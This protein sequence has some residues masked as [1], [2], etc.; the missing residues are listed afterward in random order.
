MSHIITLFLF[1]M[2]LY[3]KVNST[4][5]IV[6]WTITA[7]ML[8]GHISMAAKGKLVHQRLDALEKKLGQKEA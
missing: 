3:E 4:A 2:F 6:T 7:L 8:F 1:G 5:G